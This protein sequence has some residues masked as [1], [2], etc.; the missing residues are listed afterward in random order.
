MKANQTLHPWLQDLINQASRQEE[1]LDLPPI[2]RVNLHQWPLF[3]Q[4]PASDQMIDPADLPNPPEGVILCDW[5]T[6]LEDHA[7]LFKTH[8]QSVIPLDQHKVTAHHYRHLDRGLFIYVPDDTQVKDWLELTIDLS[9]GAHQQVLLVMGRNSRLTLVESLYNQTAAQAS[10]TYLAEIILEEGAQ[11]DYIAKDQAKSQTTNYITRQARVKNQAQLQWAMA[12]FNQGQ[13]LVDTHAL[14][15]G[16]GAHAD[17]A[18]VAL[19]DGHHQ[20]IID[21]KLTNAGPHSTAHIHQHGVVLDQGRLTMNGVG[22]IHKGAKLADAQQENRLLMLSDQARGDANPILMID[23]FE[24][25][26]GHAA[27]V[28]Q[29]DE[30]QLWYLMSRGIPRQEA[31]WLVIRGFLMQAISQI[32]D[33]AG[34]QVI[35]QALDQQLQTLDQPQENRHE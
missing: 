21:S 17:L 20:Q 34:R 35:L 29:V 31:E 16:S 10:Q 30:T 18:L 23:E 11:L 1:G 12:S 9:Q 7:D 3:D 33:Q 5:Q 13:S 2:E 22:K 32:K 25:T 14:L 26:A 15:E 19:S 28:A 8:L 6:A 4:A 24:V 27:S